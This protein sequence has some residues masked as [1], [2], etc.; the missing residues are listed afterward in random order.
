MTMRLLFISIFLVPV[1]LVL[2]ALIS[3]G[4]G[5]GLVLDYSENSIAG[6]AR[7]GLGWDRF[8]S[9][10]VLAPV[11]E[12]ALCYWVLRRLSSWGRWKSVSLVATVA[13][14]LHAFIFLDVRYFSVFP[15]FFAISL[16]ITMGKGG[17][18]ASVLHH[19]LLNAMFLI[20][21]FV[22]VAR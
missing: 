17:Y 22:Y 7:A 8:F 20:A 18:L 12:N 14:I 3:L 4:V 9:A 2:T 10:L 13:A 16:L 11:L 5:E 6:I 1:S 15:S 21:V 19:S